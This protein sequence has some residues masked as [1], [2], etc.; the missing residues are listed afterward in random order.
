M[1]AED[2]AVPGVGELR[3]WSPSTEDGEIRA[4]LGRMA[5]V[6]VRIARH[7]RRPLT[8]ERADLGPAPPLPVE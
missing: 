6:R 7:P 1:T 3:A 8:D 4:L 5:P 2:E